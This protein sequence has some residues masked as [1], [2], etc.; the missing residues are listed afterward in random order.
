MQVVCVKMSPLQT[1]LYEHFLESK[2]LSAMMSGKE[3]GVLASI[4]ALR[5]LVN[6]PKLIYDAMRV[7]ASVN[8]P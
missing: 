8:S 4:T 1:Q 3:S 7:A 6:H 5:K 2:N